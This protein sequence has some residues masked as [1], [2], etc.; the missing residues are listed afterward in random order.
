MIDWLLILFIV[1]SIVLFLDFIIPHPFWLISK[2]LTVGVWIILLIALF[3]RMVI[4]GVASVLSVV[5][6]PAVL[7]F[8][9]V[10]L[11]LIMYMKLRDKDKITKRR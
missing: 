9:A 3:V 1:M 4:K 6:H 8:I 5:T 2:P 10:F 11:V 7:S